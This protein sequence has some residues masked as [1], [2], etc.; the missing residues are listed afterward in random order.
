MPQGREG[1]GWGD[2]QYPAGVSVMT[3]SW[4][5]RGAPPGGTGWS[6]LI[7]LD[8]ILDQKKNRVGALGKSE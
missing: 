2:P 7:V 8:W 4:Q 3:K 1:T 6:K 5:E